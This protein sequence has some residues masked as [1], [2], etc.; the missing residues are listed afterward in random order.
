M[1]ALTLLIRKGRRLNSASTLNDDNFVVVFQERA[2][3]S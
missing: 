2:F 1:R 3:L